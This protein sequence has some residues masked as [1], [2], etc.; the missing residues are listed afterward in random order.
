MDTEAKAG[1]QTD[2]EDVSGPEVLINVH[3]W[4][5]AVWQ[6][7]SSKAVAKRRKS[8]CMIAELEPFQEVPSPGV[9]QKIDSF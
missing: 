6:W 8:V 9:G 7:E 2:R 5:F 4:G 3:N 1:G